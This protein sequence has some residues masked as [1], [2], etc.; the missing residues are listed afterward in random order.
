LS[1]DGVVCNAH[2]RG[3]VAMDSFFLLQVTHIFEGELKKHPRLAIV[4]EGV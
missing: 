3:I 2:R 4:V 1:F